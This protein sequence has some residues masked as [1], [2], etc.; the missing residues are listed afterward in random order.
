[1]FGCQVASILRYLGEHVT[2]LTSMNLRD[3]LYLK[4]RCLVLLLTRAHSGFRWIATLHMIAQTV[5]L[6]RCN[7]CSFDIILICARRSENTSV[8][9]AD[10][11]CML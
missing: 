10:K 7:H 6:L 3:Y 2:L 1:M 9:D 8:A 5:A 11:T 4:V